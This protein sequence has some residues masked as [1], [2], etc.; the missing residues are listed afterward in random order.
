MDRDKKSIDNVQILDMISSPEFKCFVPSTQWC[1]QTQSCH[2]QFLSSITIFGE[3]RK[4]IILLHQSFFSFILY[5][6]PW[7]GAIEIW[8]VMCQAV[9]SSTAGEVKAWK[10]LIITQIHKT[11]E[12]YQNHKLI[13]FILTKYLGYNNRPVSRSTQCAEDEFP[14]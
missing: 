11:P 3:K 7:N 8:L 12:N 14:D 9:N 1:H 5:S 2:F 13:S 6:P 4:I 10:C